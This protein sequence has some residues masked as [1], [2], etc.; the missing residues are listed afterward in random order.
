MNSEERK[1]AEFLNSKLTDRTEHV[2]KVRIVATDSVLSKTPMDIMY[3]DCTLHGPREKVLNDL[4]QYHCDAT[5]IRSLIKQRKP[6]PDSLHTRYCGDFRAIQRLEV[7]GGS[8]TALDN[9][10]VI[11]DTDGTPFLTGREYDN[12]L[13]LMQLKIQSFTY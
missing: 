6:L 12:D 5:I 3:N 1:I 13:S 7:T 11:I 8:G 2:L 4:L 10:E 9:V